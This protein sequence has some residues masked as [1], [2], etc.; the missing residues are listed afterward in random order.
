MGFMDPVAVE[1]PERGRPLTPGAN[2]GDIAT[3]TV[4]FGHGIA[5]S[6]LHLALGYAAL[7]NGG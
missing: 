3:M 7:F 4:G 6:P 5:V 2:W 1:L